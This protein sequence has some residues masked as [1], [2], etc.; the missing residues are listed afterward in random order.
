MSVRG[1]KVFLGLEGEGWERM[2]VKRALTIQLE[3]REESLRRE[4]LGGG[5]GM[6]NE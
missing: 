4:R 5:G 1:E 2:Q 6:R 3:G